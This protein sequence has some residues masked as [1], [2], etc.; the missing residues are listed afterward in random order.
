MVKTNLTVISS[1]V[2]L[3]FTHYPNVEII[4]F[5]LCLLMYLVT[6]LGNII[7][8]CISILD[9]RLHTPMYFFLSNLSFLDIWYTSSALTP[10]LANFVS[11]TNTISFSG[12]ASQMYFS[13]AMG[14]TEC[15]LLSLMA[16]D[17]YVAI[18]KPLRYPTIMN[19]RVCVQIAA[20]SWATGC[21]TSLVESVSVLH[22]P[23]C[24]NNIINHFTCEI[25]AILKLVCV[26][27]SKVQFIMLVIS[28]LLLPMPMLLIC[29]SY[30]FI[31]T[32][33]LRIASGEGR[34]KAFSTCAAHLTVVVLFYGTA[35]SM[36]LKPSTVN[37]Q[38]ID[39]FMA[40]VY[41]GLTPMLNPLIYSLR[42]KEVKAAVKKLLIR[43]PL[44]TLLIH[45]SK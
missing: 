19:K 43:N 33:I 41:A 2:F 37:S 11:G 17:R 28:I 16:Y 4:I 13:L 29:I 40:L 7:L 45:S 27:T 30:A 35:L 14:S 10:M 31:L 22:Q 8:I 32:N 34:S 24:G 44:C 9:S 3:G 39:K 5:V 1:F 23:L 42:N 26:D 15:V 18:C 12:C 6:L 20:G 25:L 21:L 36:Y 38:E